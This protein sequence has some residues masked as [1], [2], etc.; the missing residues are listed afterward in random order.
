MARQA[1]ILGARAIKKAGLQSGVVLVVVLWLLVL[2]G[3]MVSS[4]VSTTRMESELV[5]NQVNGVRARAAAEAGI[6]T[7]IDMLA[8]ERGEEERELRTDGRVYLMDYTDIKVELNVLDEAG[9]IDIN[10]VRPEMLRSL[11]VPLVRDAEKAMQITDSIIDWRDADSIRHENG[12]EDE[13][14]HKA[15][16]GYGAKD[17]YFDNLEELLLVNGVD[18]ELYTKLISL[19]TTH[20]GNSGVNPEVA[21]EQVLLA[22]P[23]VEYQKVRD[24]IKLR[25]S[26]YK[27]EA[28][29]P[30]FPV[31]DS[32]YISHD[33]DHTYT[34][35]VQATTQ[36]GVSERISALVSVAPQRAKN[37]MLP[38]EIL[39]WNS[40]DRTALT[41]L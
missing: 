15:G 35:Y 8:R 32:K 3:V 21:Q 41:K 40:N 14:Y 11:I 6:Y 24:Y 34:I 30:I 10:A 18:G 20:S 16:R 4:L 38:Y 22:I 13:D 1:Q 26:Y 7:A 19:L 12:A 2:L 5:R 23:G 27:Q 39:R 37:G 31:Q 36:D 17:E 9:K 25:D 28:P 29:M 33:R